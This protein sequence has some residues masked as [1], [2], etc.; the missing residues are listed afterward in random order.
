MEQAY[1]AGIC[2]LKEDQINYGQKFSFQGQM[3]IML[4]HEQKT[5]SRRPT[6]Y[7]YGLSTFVFVSHSV[8][9]HC[10]ALKNVF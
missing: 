10:E 6:I 7:H 1:G 9:E 8:Y 2:S 5:L 3:E 4:H